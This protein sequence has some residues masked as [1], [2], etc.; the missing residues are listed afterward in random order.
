MKT[1][2]GYAKNI[3]IIF[4]MFVEIIFRS[5]VAGIG[6]FFLAIAYY[7]IPDDNNL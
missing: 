7:V 1:I 3:L 5:I 2:I 6:L 4:S